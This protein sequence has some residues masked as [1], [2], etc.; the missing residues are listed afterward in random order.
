MWYS[1]LGPRAQLHLEYDYLL[2][3]SEA[4]ACETEKLMVINFRI[5][6]FFYIYLFNSTE[7]SQSLV[8]RRLKTCQEMQ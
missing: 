5:H 3:I 7:I 1:L 2:H 4:K 6:I 8:G